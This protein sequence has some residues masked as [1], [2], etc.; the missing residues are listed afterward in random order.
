MN[1]F[2]ILDFSQ[3][4]LTFT[5]LHLLSFKPVKTVDLSHQA[6]MSKSRSYPALSLGDL[7]LWDVQIPYFPLSYALGESFVQ[8][9]HHL[10][11][12]MVHLIL[13]EYQDDH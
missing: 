4:N 3:S 12:T 6:A 11:E 2:E 13:Q 1:S 7:S 8:I 9:L 5:S 10:R